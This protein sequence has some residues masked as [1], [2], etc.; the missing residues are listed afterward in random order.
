LELT[1]M[2][3]L[4]VAEAYAILV[5]HFE[6]RD[7]LSS[8]VNVTLLTRYL[9]PRLKGASHDVAGQPRRGI[10]IRCR[11]ELRQFVG[12]TDPPGGR[13]A[14]LKPVA[15]DGHQ[16]R[17]IGVGIVQLSAMLPGAAIFARR[18]GPPG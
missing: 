15:D 3:E 12:T 10:K 6:V 4:G 14:A 17:P 2:V 16:R 5:D 11:T 13:S 7:L 8:P 18:C 1:P 9:S